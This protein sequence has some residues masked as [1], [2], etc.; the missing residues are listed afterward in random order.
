MEWKD[1]KDFK[2]SEVVS[3]I[4]TLYDLYVQTGKAKYLDAGIEGV[5]RLKQH[6]EGLKS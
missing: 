2:V 4:N 3:V 5:D 1:T 6:L